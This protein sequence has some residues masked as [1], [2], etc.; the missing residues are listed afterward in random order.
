ML[1][2]VIDGKEHVIAYGS[3]LLSNAEYRYCVTRKELLAVV[4]FTKYYRQYLLGKQFTLR[5]DHAALRWLQKT[6]EPIGQQAR[7]LERLAEFN[8]EIVHRPGRRHGNADA[9]SRKPCR[10]CGRNEESIMIAAARELVIAQTAATADTWEQ[11][12]RAQKEDVDLSK[13]RK[14]FEDGGRIPELLEIL[15]ENSRIK[16]YWHQ[17]DRL[18]LRSGVLYRNQPNASEQVILP[19]SLREEFLK[20]AHTG[21]T[22]GHL[23]VRRTRWQVRRRAYWVGWSSEVKRF[24]HCCPQCN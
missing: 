9:L 23:G 6:P 2:Q 12:E 4:Y 1:S 11:M 8:F 10:Q 24:C 18:F 19:K 15:Y 21:V 22:G 17:K 20:L 16:T 5:T 7:W 13:V 3:R 14:W